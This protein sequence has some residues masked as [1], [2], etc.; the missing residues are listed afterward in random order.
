MKK[1]G[2]TC[3]GKLKEKYFSDA[4]EEY[5]KRLSPY[6]ELVIHALD[7][8][9]GQNEIEKESDAILATFKEGEERIL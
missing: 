7:D 5:R 9:S 6:C 3:V 2:L 1:I 4:V 8:V